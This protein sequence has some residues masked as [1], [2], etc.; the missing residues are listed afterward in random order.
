[1][2]L[3]SHA[4]LNF[5]EFQPD[6]QEVIANCQ[7]NDV[8][9]VNVGSQLATSRKAAAI[10]A[11]YDQGVYAAVGQHPI[12]AAGSTFHPENFLVSDYQELISSSKKIVAVGEIGLDFFHAADNLAAQKQLLIGQLRLAQTNNLPVIIHA[13]NSRDGRPDAY[14]EILKI[15]KQ[16]KTKNGVIHC[17]GG[18]VRQAKEFLSLGFYVGFTGIITFDKTGQLAEVVKNL[19]LA[20]IL[21][22]TDCPYLAPAPHRGERNRPEYVKFTA[23]KIAEIQGRTYNEVVS[24]TA[25][26]ALNLF[27]IF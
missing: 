17:F 4:H 19:P 21:I 10:A 25:K 22:E 26:N 18:N 14:E 15:L 12:H 27:K 2:L 16:E 1:M 23:E 13:R 24:Q 3:D 5:E 9:L 7:K 6:W 11:K 20:A 8:W